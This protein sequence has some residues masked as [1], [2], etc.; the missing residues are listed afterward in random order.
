MNKV[1]EA[2]CI[3]FVLNA[4]LKVTDLRNNQLR[5]DYEYEINLSNIIANKNNNSPKKNTIASTS[6]TSPH[7]ISS[8]RLEVKILFLF[9]LL[10]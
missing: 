4:N 3:S 10:L 6:P 8:S 5:Q 7:V 1:K 2:T 9:F